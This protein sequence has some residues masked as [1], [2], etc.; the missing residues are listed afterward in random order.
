MRV[1]N[2]RPKYT[3]A[4]VIKRVFTHTKE[5]I[6]PY[7]EGNRGAVLVEFPGSRTEVED[8]S[9]KNAHHKKFISEEATLVLSSDLIIDGKNRGKPI[10]ILVV[11][12]YMA[13][14][15]QLSRHFDNLSRIR[16][17]SSHPSSLESPTPCIVI[18]FDIVYM[19]S[20][21]C[22]WSCQ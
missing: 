2:V 13:Q 3:E 22:S 11:C 6:C 16:S 5:H 8:N 14:V 17:S 9:K 19:D 15:R 21:R 18:P 4:A 20:A 7:V 12:Y 10:K 1:K